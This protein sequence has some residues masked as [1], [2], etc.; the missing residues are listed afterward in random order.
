MRVAMLAHSTNP[1]GGVVH[2][3]CLSEALQSLGVEVVLHAPDASG[4]GFFRQASNA[5]VAFPVAPPR[6]RLNDMIPQ[7]VADYFRWFEEPAHRGFDVYHA[8]DGISANALIQLKRRGLI[9]GFVRTVHHID[10]FADAEVAEWQRRSIAE[11]DALMVV[12]EMWRPRLRREFGFEATL[13]G[14]GVDLVRYAP[15]PDGREQALRAKLA[16]DG[17]PIFLSLGGVEER[18]NTF[19]LL[20]AFGKVLDTH[21][22]ALLVIAG[23][24]TLLDHALYRSEFRSAL[25]GLGSKGRRVRLAGPIA[26]EDM[27]ALYRLADAYVCP[28]VKEG[29]GLCVIEA[30]ACGRPVVVSKIEPF[31][32]YLNADEARWCNPYEPTSIAVAMLAA[33]TYANGPAVAARFPWSLV[34]ERHCPVYEHM[35]EAAHA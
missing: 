34:A 28:S 29:F 11:A 32:D 2:A 21:P 16:L 18:K 17:G 25:E 10:E 22:Q 8:H 3:M 5:A 12:S 4:R 20:I 24:A 1:R 7:R 6:A 31:T 13:G 33:R 27:P 30:L 23:G 35:R 9:A 19:R 26:D 14:N 15:T